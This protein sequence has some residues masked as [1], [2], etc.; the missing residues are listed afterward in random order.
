MRYA[1]TSFVL[2][3]DENWW[4]TKLNKQLK[5]IDIQNFPICETAGFGDNQMK[6]ISI[7]NFSKRRIY[8]RIV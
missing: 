1:Q 4:N 2:Q 5:W 3:K 8:A 7:Q 6:S